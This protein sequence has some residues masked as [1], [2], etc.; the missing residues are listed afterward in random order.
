ML[1][2]VLQV[3]SLLFFTIALS[4]PSRSFLFHF[5]KCFDV[6]LKK[7]IRFFLEMPFFINVRD[8]VPFPTASTSSFVVHVPM[9]A[10]SVD[11][12]FI[13]MYIH[14]FLNSR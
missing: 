7:F 14:W 5:E 13:H 11:F 10:C 6:S 3:V 4:R 9:S 1:H 2:L 8:N 12:L